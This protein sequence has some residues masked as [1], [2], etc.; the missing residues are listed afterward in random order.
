LTAEL[1]AKSPA[2]GGAVP[3]GEGVPLPDKGLGRFL[4]LMIGVPTFVV[5]LTLLALARRRTAR[6]G[7]SRQPP[8][9]SPPP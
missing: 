5:L 6:P 9:A 7:P 8:A 2:D 4:P 3:Q 1:A